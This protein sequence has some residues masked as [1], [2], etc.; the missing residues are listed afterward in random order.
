MP[1]DGP[2]PKTGNSQDIGADAARCF[3]ARM[4]SNWRPHP[5]DGTDDYGLDFQIQTTP[6]QRATDVFRVQLK[7]TRSPEVSADGTFISITLKASTVRYYDRIVEPI[8]LVVCDLSVDSDPVDC[9][10]YYAWVHDELRRIA[11]SELDPDQT[12]VTLRV[13]VS[14]RVRSTTDL[15]GDLD[16]QNELAR[17]GHALGVVVERTHAGMLVEE[18]VGFVQRM[19]TG[20]DQR[21]AAFLD[22]L[23]A[24]VEQHWIE[25]SAGSLAWHLKEAKTLLKTSLL[26]RAEGELSQAARLLPG[27]ELEIGEYWFLSGK[28]N[29]AKGYDE[30]ASEAFRKAYEAS[31]SGKHV[32]AYVESELRR[33]YRDGAQ[34]Q[35]HP[36]LLELLSGNDSMVL[37][38]RSRVL[39]AEGKLDDAVAVADM[40]DGV[41]RHSARALAHTMFGKSVEAVADCDAGLACADLSDN[42]RQ[43]LLVLK[44]RSKFAISQAGL[45]LVDGE[46]LPPSGTAGVDGVLVKDAWVAIEEALAVLR[47]AGWGSNIDLVA[48]IWAATASMLAKQKIVLPELS[49]VA[50]LRPNC[51]NL[52]AALETIASQCGD[53]PTAL[54][55]ND[56]LQPSDMR[57][58]RRTLSLHEAGRHGDC[59]KWFD[60]NFDALDRN[61]ALFGPATTV[62]AL[63]AHK[64]IKPELVKRWSN[65]LDLHTHLREHAA[66]LQYQLATE[67]NSIGNEAA[68]EQ[69]TARYEE[70]DRPFFLSI[71]LLQ[72]LNPTIESQAR[73][74]VQV[75]ERARE[76]AEPSP[77]MAVHVGMA[78]TTLKSWQPLLEWCAAFKTR[79]DA[80]PKMQAFEAL[81]LDRLG[82]TPEARILLESMLA[83]GVLDS[84]ALNTY[85]SI[86][87]RCGYVAEAI[88]AAE[89][90]ME[91]A[92]DVRRQMECTRL[93]FNLIQQ[94]DPVSERLL[95]LALQMG[96]LASPDA[97]IEEGI[98]LTMFLT[99]TLGEHAKPPASAISEF[100]R[101]SQAFFER[102]PNSKIIKQAQF[103]D[104]APGSEIW[105]QIKNI[106]GITEDRE[107][108]QR[109]LENQMQR[110]QA[111]APF[112]WRPRLILPTVGDVVHLWEIAKQSSVDDKKYHLTMLND[113][114]WSP[115][116][117]SSLRA[118]TPLFDMTALLVVFDLGLLDTVIGFFG[119][120]AIAKSTLERLA[121]F[122]NPFSG[123]YARSK[124]IALQDALKVHLAVIEQPSI[125]DFSEGGEDI[126]GDAENA[127]SDDDGDDRIYGS[128]HRE[129]VRLCRQ[130][131]TYRLYSDDLA[132]RILTAESDHPDGICTMDVLAGLH[133]AG[134]ITK[135]IQAQKVSSL[136][137][138]RVG[139]VVPMDVITS[140]F[141]DDLAS[142]STAK[143]GMERLDRQLELKAV[144]DAVWDFRSP[145][146]KMLAHAAAVA[147]AMA[148]DKMFSGTVIA[149][150]LGQWFVKATM[151]NDAPANPLEAMAKVIVSAAARPELSSVSA[152]KLWLAYRLLVEFHHGSLMDEAREADAIRLLGRECASIYKLNA[153][154]GEK[155]HAS[156]RS[157]LTEGTSDDSHF[158]KG[159]SDALR[160]IGAPSK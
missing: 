7:G 21:S 153:A 27:T 18:R 154:V 118:R 131:D 77:A 35:A 45:A 3:G 15:S 117:A 62:A 108:F 112:A 110:G 81:A 48:D 6:G 53:F 17:A 1:V 60:K 72:E 42:S 19:A 74:C 152:S 101:R 4:P 56:R 133:E 25:P 82:R 135:K 34:A 63:S 125:A 70:F 39:A 12:Y 73:L 14:N 26:D 144:L 115:P 127:V 158:T 126:D 116:S 95:A 134:L 92:V 129:L 86:M 107:A 83:G 105:A 2:L 142:A 139:V 145:F 58:L 79:I 136:C 98:Y 104:D 91:S 50:K 59:C 54:E 140:L 49:A 75:A 41:E 51:Q 30:Q 155:V 120:I 141:P 160:Q 65:E 57:N 84:L 100:Q 68:L 150:F 149:A 71:V 102:F 44:A 146:D 55:A 80:W 157:G 36:D 87:V 22:A 13:P 20:L 97:E 106:A 151:K 10:L 124:C 99:A 46:L 148:D 67:L 11:I 137:G 52:Q 61:H 113:S 90:I 123:S 111:V 66:L 143:Y 103:R 128:E 89:K 93:L 24:P 28:W 43:M 156:L 69:L 64:L 9:P 23:A 37:S 8:L 78:L 16:A 40:L 85:I 88:D 33:R 109:K 76:R 29:L 114:A 38:A 147:S 32:A 119:K 94:S 47:D 121:G 130:D 138:W 31:W 159:F 96:R 5:L 122:V 132:F